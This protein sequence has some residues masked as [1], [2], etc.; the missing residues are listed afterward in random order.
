MEFLGDSVLGLVVNE[1]LYRLFPNNREGSL[2]Q[3]KSLLVSEAIL[4]KMAR[5]MSLGR[6][7][8][9]SE[10]E[11][12]SGGRDRSS[13]LADAFEAVIGAIYLDSGIDA[14]RRF[15]E[16]R[17][18][19]E[20]G[21]IVGDKSHMNHKSR[22]QEF[23][24]G[25][26]KTHPRY[27]VSREDGPDHEKVFSVEVFVSDRL[28]GR[29]SGKNKKDAEQDAARDAI[30]RMEAEEALD[31]SKQARRADDRRHTRPSRD[32]YWSGGHRQKSGRR[33]RGTGMEQSRHSR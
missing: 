20:A 9:L 33:R 16:G 1:H 26:F 15:T 29:G 14:A 4:S 17:L 21:A 24:Q 8:Y 3:M 30:D 5:S 2:T 6:Y 11:A 28:L 7:L 31:S 10:A 32:R 12:D 19:R 18:L 23:A 22:L 13:I 25:R 27:R